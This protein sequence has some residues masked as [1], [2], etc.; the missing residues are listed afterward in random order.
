M[1]NVSASLGFGAGVR[2]SRTMVLSSA[3]FRSMIWEGEKER[4]LV[5]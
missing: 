4:V 1:E 5:V 3:N 2:R